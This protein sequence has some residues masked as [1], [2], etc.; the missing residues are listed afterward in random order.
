MNDIAGCRV[1]LPNLKEVNKLVGKLSKDKT[2]KKFRDYINT[3]RDSG[4]RSI[5]M[6]GK[7]LNPEYD[8]YM[9]VELQIRTNIQHSWATAVEIV[10]LFTKDSI[11]TNQGSKEWSEFFIKLSKLFFILRQF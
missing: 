11:K 10:D 9:N 5:H 1:I 8:K 3:P 7:F 4:Y 2:F 6:I